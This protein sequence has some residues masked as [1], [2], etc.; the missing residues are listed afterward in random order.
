MIESLY[1]GK[2]LLT[3]PQCTLHNVKVRLQTDQC[4]QGIC[5]RSRRPGRVWSLDKDGSWSVLGW[6]W[7]L[8]TAGY[9]IPD[10]WGYCFLKR[11][12]HH[13]C[14]YKTRRYGPLRG[15]TTS[16][17]EGLRPLAEGFFALLSKEEISMMFWPIF[18][19]FWC[20]VV[21]MVTFSSNIS[22]FTRKK[23]K[24]KI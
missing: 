23:K 9:Y 22:N 16:S 21:T 18:V 24:K 2:R 11:G 13:G 6:V 10:H 19:I 3:L 5:N 17:C 14:F 1:N 20:P 15:P 12:M 8:V 4:H 7:Q